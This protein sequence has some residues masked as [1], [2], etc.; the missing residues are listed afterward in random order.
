VDTAQGFVPLTDT[1]ASF[2]AMLA[3][4]RGQPELSDFFCTFLATC[5]NARMLLKKGDSLN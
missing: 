3:K 4:K 1:Q 2:E 5:D